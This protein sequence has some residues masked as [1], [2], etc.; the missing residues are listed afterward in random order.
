MINPV[1]SSPSPPCPTCG[2]P[3][4]LAQIAPKV[5]SFPELH[6]FR[7][8]ACGDVRTV[9]Q[10]MYKGVL[11]KGLEQLR[12][13]S[14]RLELRVVMVSDI[15]ADHITDI[16]DMLRDLVEKQADGQEARYG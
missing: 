15:D 6:T 3:M 2:K 12:S 16:V 4:T 1:H 10:I 7:C 8:H 14:P 9:E 5:A 13:S 11:K